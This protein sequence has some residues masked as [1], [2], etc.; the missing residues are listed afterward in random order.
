MPLTTQSVVAHIQASARSSLPP[1]GL[2]GPSRTR[3]SARSTPYQADELFVVGLYDLVLQ[4]EP[5][6]HGFAAHVDALRQGSTRAELFTGLHGS[7]EARA[8]PGRVSADY[9]DEYNLDTLVIRGLQLE[10]EGELRDDET[11]ARQH[12]RWAAGVPL[13]VLAHELDPVRSGPPWELAVARAMASLL[14]VPEREDRVDDMVAQLHRGVPLES[15]IFTHVPGRGPRARWRR[16]VL[17]SRAFDMAQLQMIY[18]LPR[19][20]PGSATDRRQ[21]VAR[22]ANLDASIERLNDRVIALQRVVNDLKA[23]TGDATGAP[24]QE[25]VRVVEIGSMLL[26]VPAAEWRLAAFLEHRGHPEPGFWS[27]MTRHIV[28]GAHFVDVGANLGLYTVAAT[29]L[30]GSSGRVTAFEPAPRTAQMLRDNVQLNGLLE[31][32]RVAIHEKAAG[33]VRGTGK[34]AVYDADSGH[35]SLYSKELTDPT[36]SVEI[37][38]LDEVFPPGT[39]VDVVKIDA[40]GAELEV[41]R[42]MQRIA[43]DNPDIVVFAELAAEHLTRAETSIDALIAEATQRGW[44]HDIFETVS[45]EHPEPGSELPLSVYLTRSANSRS[46]RSPL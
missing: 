31:T 21:D 46:A 23:G 20:T 19:M 12:E 38:P 17:A 16:H 27:L 35:N 40:E 44:D 28:P 43:E 13:G 11:I 14:G 9:P 36:V 22:R 4:R 42:G 37:V 30:V 45:G 33:A 7:M 18:S 1:S 39:K 8:I 6:P 25:A 5:D 32:G 10:V 2:S 24:A 29:S 15:A 34:L 3:K 41:L 26:G